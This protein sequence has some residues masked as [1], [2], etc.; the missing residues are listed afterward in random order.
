MNLALMVKTLSNKSRMSLVKP[1]SDG[2]RPWETN[3]SC[4]IFKILHSEK[5]IVRSCSDEEPA[6]PLLGLAGNILMQNRV[7]C[8]GPQHLYSVSTAP[9]RAAIATEFV[10]LPVAATGILKIL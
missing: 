8:S 3:A 10:Q 2:T 5:D 9:G 1:S 7:V 4:I 6:A